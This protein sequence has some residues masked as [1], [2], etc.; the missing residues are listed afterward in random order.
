M[1]ETARKFAIAAEGGPAA[2]IADALYA[3]ADELA[4][5][6]CALSYLAATQYEG[7]GGEQRLLAATISETAKIRFAKV[8]DGNQAIDG[9]DMTELDALW[10]RLTGGK[11]LKR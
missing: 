6:R 11:K 3:V 2:E 1:S 9:M 5:I 7:T 8:K 4:G 10:S